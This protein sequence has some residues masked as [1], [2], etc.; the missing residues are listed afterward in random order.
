MK[1]KGMLIAKEDSKAE[2]ICIVLEGTLLKF[3]TKLNGEK[4]PVGMLSQGE[5]FGMEQFYLEDKR[6]G[7]NVVAA[8]GSV[9]FVFANQFH[10]YHVRK[11]LPLPPKAYT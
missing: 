5:M 11:S 9:A 10:R 8:S 6:I 3:I 7:F 4:E 1:S 2:E